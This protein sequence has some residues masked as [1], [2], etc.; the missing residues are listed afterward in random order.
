VNAEALAVAQLGDGVAVA[1]RQDGGWFLA[2]APQK[3]EYANETHFLTQAD[4][5]ERLAVWVFAEP[6]HALA[7]MTDGL[8]RLVLD[9]ERNTPHLP[10]F[11]PLLA[12]AH[13][14]RDEDQGRA[15]LAA[16]LGS[17]RVSARTDDDTTLVLAVRW[18][19][20]GPADSHRLPIHASAA[21]GPSLQGSLAHAARRASEPLP[22]AGRQAGAAP[23]GRRPV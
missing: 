18:P 19:P 15:E 7:V 23:V 14:V 10:F 16:F 3:G 21:P 17:D 5:L 6:V 13:E 4:A 1:A 12:F 8:L 20:P 11:R 2:A 22:E 9:L